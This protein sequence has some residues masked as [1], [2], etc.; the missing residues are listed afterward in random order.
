[1]P[2]PA[3]VIARFTASLFIHLSSGPCAVAPRSESIS[4]PATPAT[5]TT[6]PSLSPCGPTIQVKPPMTA[7]PST[8]PAVPKKVIP[9]LAPVAT[10]AP[11]VMRR[12]GAEE[13]VPISVAHVSA[14]AAASAPANA[15]QDPSSAATA[16]TPPFATTWRALRRPP[17]RVNKLPETKKAR[18]SNQPR[19]PTPQ[20]VA[21]PTASAAAAPAVVSHLT[22]RIARAGRDV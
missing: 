16:A 22:R 5:A 10:E 1:M 18:S 17:P 13:R 6:A 9:P 14:A 12:G 11:V 19:Q 8:P 7:A 20:T 15:G 3:S 21:T 2:A 4:M